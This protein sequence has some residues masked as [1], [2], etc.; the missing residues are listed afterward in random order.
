MVS[1]LPRRHTIRLNGYDYAFEGLYFVTICVTGRASLLG[2]V[3]DGGMK[4]NA[5]GKIVDD[6]WRGMFPLPEV[7][8]SDTWIVMPNHLH[9]IIATNSIAAGASRSAPT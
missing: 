4:Q 6:V 1:F 9:G 8:D 7:S 5:L 2:E 3:V